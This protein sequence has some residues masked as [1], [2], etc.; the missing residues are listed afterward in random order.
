MPVDTQ[1]GT[2]PCIR[3]LAG[4]DEGTRVTVLA[5]DWPA[6]VARAGFAEAA[7]QSGSDPTDLEV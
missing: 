3:S 1:L 7:W 4:G 5:S 2:K 6:V